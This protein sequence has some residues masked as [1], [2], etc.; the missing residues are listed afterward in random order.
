MAKK[1]KK[2]I[3][4]NHKMDHFTLIHVDKKTPNQL[5]PRQNQIKPSFYVPHH[6]KLPSWGLK[7]LLAPPLW[8]IKKKISHLYCRSKCQLSNDTKFNTPR[9]PLVPIKMDPKKK[10]C[11]FLTSPLLEIR[12]GNHL[13][14][15]LVHLKFAHAKFKETVRSRLDVRLVS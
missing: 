9:P 13:N 7:N 1:A 14:R 5:L 12:F 11:Q 2:K 3:L 10:N 15:E 6:Q 8:E 4:K